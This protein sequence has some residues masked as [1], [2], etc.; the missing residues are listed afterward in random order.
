MTVRFDVVATDVGCDCCSYVT[1]GSFDSRAEAE[2]WIVER[3][4][5]HNYTIDEESDGDGG[6]NE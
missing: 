4:N 6:R 5:P 3:T 1:R 2:A